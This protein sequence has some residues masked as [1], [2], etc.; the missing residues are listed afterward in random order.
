MSLLNPCLTINLDPSLFNR[1]LSCLYPAAPFAEIPNLS[2]LYWHYPETLGRRRPY[3]EIFELLSRSIPGPNLVSPHC[4]YINTV[5]FYAS[6][7]AL[8]RNLYY[9][10]KGFFGVSKSFQ[11]Y[12]QCRHSLQNGMIVAAPSGERFG[13]NSG[14]IRYGAHA[15]WMVF[16]ARANAVDKITESESYRKFTARGMTHAA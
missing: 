9:H 7:Y 10:R 4:C 13:V 16:A 12:G 3:L 14:T 1:G 5:I 6:P 2:D 11:E 15:W 8:G